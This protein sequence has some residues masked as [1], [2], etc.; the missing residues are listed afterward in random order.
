MSEQNTDYITILRSEFNYHLEKPESQNFANIKKD[1]ENFKSFYHSQLALLLKKVRMLGDCNRSYENDYITAKNAVLKQLDEGSSSL[2]ELNDLIAERVHAYAA[3]TMNVNSQ[4]SVEMEDYVA[5]Q[6]QE[7]L[8]ST[9][10]INVLDEDNDDGLEQDNDDEL[11]ETN[12]DELEED[13][14]DE[15]EQDNN[16]QFEEDNDDELEDDENGNSAKDPSYVPC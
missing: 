3:S 1:H 11:E 4:S 8:S 10:I 12:N 5:E 6:N 9:K 13:N 14:D 15:L 2:M 16:D 7:D